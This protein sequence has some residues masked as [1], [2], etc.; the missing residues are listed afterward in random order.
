MQEK[1]S[2]KR[3]A[4][5]GYAETYP[6]RDIF[7][8]ESGYIM[9]SLVSQDE[10]IQAYRL[11]YRIFYEELAWVP[12]SGSLLEIDEYDKYTASLGIFDRQHVL[13]ACTR[14]ALPGTPFMIEKEFSSLI[15][16][17]HKIRKQ[18]DIAEISR[19]CV[20]P[21]ARK[22]SVYGTFG[23]CRVFTLIYKVAY[24]WCSA[25]NIRYVY[26]VVEP[27]L[28]R[29]LRAQGFRMQLVGEPV[30]MPD[31]CVAMAAIIDWDEFVSVNAARRPEFAEWFT[32]YG[33]TRYEGQRLQPGSYSQPQVSP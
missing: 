23:A 8:R 31:G 28:Y 14:V 16:P 1:A 18:N 21:E 15:S 30:T 19:S 13:V 25:N 10:K 4:E 17:F 20:A 3:V 24:Q 33:S 22:L 27:R 7:I 29:V 9:K 12:R 11:R 26:T 5:T 6:V 2:R 32:H